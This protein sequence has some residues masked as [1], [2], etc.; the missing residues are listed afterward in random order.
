MKANTKTTAKRDTMTLAKLIG[1]SKVIEA[2]ANDKLP[3]K[4][5][6]KLFRFRKAA[7][8]SMEFYARKIN[9]II[10]E[11]GVK[12]DKGNPKFDEK[13][14]ALI[15]TARVNDCRTAIEELEKCEVDKPEV[16]FEEDDLDKIE[17][18]LNDLASLED[19]I[20]G[21]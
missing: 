13:G 9:E 3:Y 8:P 5:S 21:E 2:H 11:Y 6:L 19:F 16:I 12:D 14:N 18:S 7:D 1:A 4:V 10:G 20:K 15:D 17:L